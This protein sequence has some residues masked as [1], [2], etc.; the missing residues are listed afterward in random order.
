MFLYTTEQEFMVGEISEVCVCLSYPRRCFVAKLSYFG[1]TYTFD[2]GY[3]N[4]TS[5]AN[6]APPLKKVLLI[7][8]PPSLKA[9]WLCPSRLVLGLSMIVHY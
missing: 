2:A 5:F 3:Y 9:S 4:F 1:F 7:C 6:T 8:L